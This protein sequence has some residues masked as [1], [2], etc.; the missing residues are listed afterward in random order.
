MTSN[1]ITTAEA[2]AILAVLPLHP[3]PGLYI[4]PEPDAKGNLTV[5][6]L[7]ADGDQGEAICGLA[8]RGDDGWY[9]GCIECRAEIE[10]SGAGMC[11]PCREDAAWLE[12][13]RVPPEEDR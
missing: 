6:E 2:G 10:E 13:Q 5:L 7:D 12:Q 1:Q 3:R 8:V 9:L 11:R 4:N